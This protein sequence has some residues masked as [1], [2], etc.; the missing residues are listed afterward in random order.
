LALLSAIAAS[1][2][3]AAA[4][5][6]SSFGTPAVRVKED[7]NGQTKGSY[8]LPQPGVIRYTTSGAEGAILASSDDAPSGSVQPDAP[9]V[10]P[11]DVFWQYDFPATGDV[12]GTDDLAELGCAHVAQP[13]TKVTAS[14]YRLPT[15]PASFSGVVNHSDPGKWYVAGIVG[16][17]PPCGSCTVTWTVSST[18]S[19][20]TVDVEPFDTF[21][22]HNQIYSSGNFYNDMGMG[23]TKVPSGKPLVDSWDAGSTRHVEPNTLS[24]YKFQGAPTGPF[25]FVVDVKGN[26][27]RITWTVN[28]RSSTVAPAGN[29]SGQTGQGEPLSFTVTAG[30][31]NMTKFRLPVDYTCTRGSQHERY[32][33]V[34]TSS[35][36]ALSGPE[37]DGDGGRFSMSFTSSTEENGAFH[38]KGSVSAVYASG[39]INGDEVEA[40]GWNCSAKPIRYTATPN[41]TP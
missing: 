13:T 7:C 41:G 34:L 25:G 26:G 28:I 31:R 17:K 27:G 12:G 39:V 14:A 1:T 15:T 36:Q 29:F 5:I 33:T 19:G 30:G 4:A 8:N 18:A 11:G 10:A 37:K 6:A 35:T 20:G 40:G 3:L 9:S 21:A 2:F 24:P 22:E 23:W 16:A 38:V 32:R